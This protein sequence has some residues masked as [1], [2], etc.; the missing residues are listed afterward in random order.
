MYSSSRLEKDDEQPPPTCICCQIDHELMTSLVS[1]SAAQLLA[2]GFSLRIL[3][4]T[5]SS[6]ASSCNL[7]GDVARAHS[8]APFVPTRPR[9]CDATRASATR[10]GMTAGERGGGPNG[11]RHSSIGEQ[12]RWGASSSPAMYGVGPSSSSSHGG[13]GEL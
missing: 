1:M 3:G 13:A 4:S 5:S 8:P 6:P 2:R 9:P 12:C 11:C 7:S 10:G